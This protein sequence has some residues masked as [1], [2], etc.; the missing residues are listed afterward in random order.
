MQVEIKVLTHVLWLRSIQV[1]V[2]AMTL[3][4]GTLCHN[5]T[6]TSRLV[7][8]PLGGGLDDLGHP[9]TG[10]SGS[11]LVSVGIMAVTATL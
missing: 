3:I 10:A 6:V 2:F 1:F 9:G 7:D 5:Y 8:V 4:L 11:S